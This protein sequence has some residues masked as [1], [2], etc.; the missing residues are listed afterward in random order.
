MCCPLPVQLVNLRR[1]NEVAL[2]QA[3]YIMRP[4]CHFGLAPSEKN[5]GM[6]SLLFSNFTH[7]IH[8][9]KRLHTVE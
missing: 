6:V 1:E 7:E 9:G 4:C 8:E 2:R 3:V 5:F